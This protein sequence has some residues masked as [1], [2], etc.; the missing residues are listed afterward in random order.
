MKK[1]A[2]LTKLLCVLLALVMLA[3]MAVSCNTEEA[4]TSN[5]TNAVATTDPVE[6]ET[7]FPE[8]GLDGINFGESVRIVVS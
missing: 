3:T 4:D 7:E 5:E 1:T 2:L 6:E 8:D